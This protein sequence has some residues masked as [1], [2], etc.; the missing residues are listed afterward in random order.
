M[1]KI[2]DHVQQKIKV[3]EAAWR[4]IR[5]S[6]IE[7]ASVRNVAQEAGVSPGSMRHYFSTQAEL[8]SFSMS[9]VSERVRKRISSLSFDR[10]A[11]AVARDVLR[12]LVPLNEE[13]RSEMEVWLAFVSKS[14]SEPSLRDHADRVHAELREAMLLV[15]R[16]LVEYDFA[17]K[18]LDIE[19]EAERMQ[20]FVDGV[21]LHGLLYPAQMP[22]AK[23]EKLLDGYLDSLCKKE[24]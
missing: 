24:R 16:G 14:L 6:G 9:L 19:E 21:A 7:N 10:P 12:E 2:V 15:V 13:S 4:V 3:A 8:F 20:V 18:E 1:P 11:S 23:M 17:P 22:S 5:R